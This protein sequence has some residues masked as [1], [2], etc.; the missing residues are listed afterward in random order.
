MQRSW[1]TDLEKLTFIIIDRTCGS[2]A[3]ILAMAGDVNMFFL[4]DS[5]DGGDGKDSVVGEVQVMIGNPSMRKKGLATEAVKLLM[6]LG[7]K[8]FAGQWFVAVVS[9]LFSAEIFAVRDRAEILCRQ[10]QE[11]QRKEC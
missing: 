10:N 9:C 3:E 11:R 1:S 5:D 4:R 7:T 2:S 8:I 6:S